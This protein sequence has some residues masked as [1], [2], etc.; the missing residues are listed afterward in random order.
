MSTAT[1]VSTTLDRQTAEGRPIAQAGAG[2]PAAVFDETDPADTA[3]R[4]LCAPRGLP[5]PAC[6]REAVACIYRPARSVMQAG[7]ANT[8]CWVLEFEP[9]SAPFIKPLMGWTGS[10]DTLQQVR[11]TFPTKERA[12]SYAERQGWPCS[13]REPHESRIRPKSYAENFRTRR[14][15]DTARRLHE[16]CRA[17]DGRAHR[18]TA[19][20]H[21]FAPEFHA[22]TH[23]DAEHGGKSGYLATVA[24][25]GDHHPAHVRP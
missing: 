4:S 24:R 22:V 11:L 8:K 15:P 16:V 20:M 5:Q 3:Q 2:R 10:A 7:Q 25:P 18:V 1:R 6:M 14:P 12:V 17:N 9:R 21:R 13:V 19:T 23:A